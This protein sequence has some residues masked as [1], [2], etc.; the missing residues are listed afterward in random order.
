MAAPQV[1]DV[2]ERQLVAPGLLVE[3]AGLV[4]FV[5]IVVVLPD[6]TRHRGLLRVGHGQQRSDRRA[7]QQW[8]LGQQP[9]PGLQLG[10]HGPARQVGGRRRIALIDVD[11]DDELVGAVQLGASVGRF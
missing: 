2:Q 3:V 5:H 11:M 9:R 4:A 7:Q 1:Q 10:M 8:R 6:I